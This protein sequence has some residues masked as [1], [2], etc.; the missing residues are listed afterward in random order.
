MTA[1]FAAAWQVPE[2]L[3]LYLHINGRDAAFL[4]QRGVKNVASPR[5]ADVVECYSGLT[6]L[7]GEGSVLESPQKKVL[8]ESFVEYRGS[9]ETFVFS[10]GGNG[11]GFATHSRTSLTKCRSSL[12]KRLP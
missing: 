4:V 6:K 10:L 8:V 9:C 12:I 11:S 5:F 2:V 7:T 3:K 1:N